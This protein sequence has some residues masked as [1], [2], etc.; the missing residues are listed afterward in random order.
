MSARLDSMQM[1]TPAENGIAPFP[2]APSKTPL[3]AYDVLS[4]TRAHSTEVFDET[5][6]PSALTAA[7]VQR[8]H[9]CPG[10]TDRHDPRHGQGPAGARAP[11]GDDYRHRPRPPRGTV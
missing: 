11:P 1:R 4:V 8:D 9:L 6:I 2:S 7:R 3:V 10:R 5:F